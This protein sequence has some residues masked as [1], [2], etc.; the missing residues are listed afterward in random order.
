M[1]RSVR[2]GGGARGV[3]GAAAAL[4]LFGAVGCTETDPPAPA[5]TGSGIIGG[6]E[7]SGWPAVGAYLVAGLQSLCTGT[8]IAPDLVL[9]AAHCEVMGNADDAFFFG[10]S[11]FG[12]GTAIMVDSSAS[13]PDYNPETKKHDLA[14]L[15]LFEEAP[16][17]PHV[18]NQEQIDDDWEGTMLHA[19]GFGT[20]DGYDGKTMG[21]KREVDVEF[22]SYDDFMIY[23]ETEGQNTCA[24]DSGG[25]LFAERGNQWV[26]AGVASFVYPGFGGEDYCSGGGGDARIDVDLVWLSGYLE[27]LEIPEDDD[28]EDDDD[29]GGYL[30]EDDGGGCKSSVGATASGPALGSA[31][32]LLAA[33]AVR[34]RATA[35]PGR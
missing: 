9:T 2:L 1:A 28:D 32:V 22:A 19:V 25:P 23:H 10:D 21:I 15:K 8:L 33:L 17:Q 14:V 29:G 24:G 26:V 4:V 7:T 16:V 18:V 20:D 12:D 11:I 5:W 27:G 6:E 30:E 3:L 35:A 13:H 31:L 34:R